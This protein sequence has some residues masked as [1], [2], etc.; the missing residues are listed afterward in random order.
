MGHFR[1]SL[2]LT[3]LLLGAACSTVQEPDAATPTPTA[4]ITTP[5][6][7]PTEA[8]TPTTTAVIPTPT[9]QPTEAA[10]TPTMQ[11]A[12]QTAPAGLIYKLSS[13]GIFQIQP[14]GQHRQLFDSQ[15]AAISNLQVS[16][17]GRYAAYVNDDQQ[18]WLLSSE[19]GMQT[20]LADSYNV[21]HFLLW[22]DNSTLL[23]GIWLDSSESE[24]PNN[25]HLARFNL[26]ADRAVHILDE[27]RL[28][29]G[30]PALSSA[31]TIAFDLIPTSANDNETSF[32]FRHDEGVTSFDPTA[33]DGSDGLLDGTRFNPAW[34]P[35]GRQLAWLTAAGERFAVQLFDLDA[36][37]AV[38]LHDWDPARFG[39]LV[40]S[41]VW[42]PD[43]KWLA[44]NVWANGTEGSGVWLL[45]ADGSSQ[46][47]VDGEGFDPRWVDAN[48]LFFSVD[49]SPRLYDVG[50][51]VVTKLDL[52]TG[53]WVL[54]FTSPN[55]L[56]ALSDFIRVDETPVAYVL[57]VQDVV[58]YNGP[59]ASY[60][61]IGTLFGGQTARVTGQ[62]FIT[63]WWRVICPDDTVGNCW[64]TAD[65][66]STIPTDDSNP[67]VALLN[68]DEL[69]I[70][71]REL[72][73][74][75]GRFQAIARRSEPISLNDNEQFY[76]EIV[77][78]NGAQTWS[79]AAGWRPYG[80]GFTYPDALSWSADSRYLYYTNHQTVGDGCDLFPSGGDL[81]RFDVEAGGGVELLPSGLA[82]SFALSPDETTIAYTVQKGSEI[83]LTLRDVA[84]YAEQSVAVATGSGQ[85]GSIVW[86]ADGTQ[87]LL[88]VAFEPCQPTQANSIVAVD[89]AAVTAVTLIDKDP[90]QFTIVEFTEPNRATLKD[91]DGQSWL[92]DLDNG[93]LTES[94]T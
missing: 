34:S 75:N 76:S 4:V 15:T 52:P 53:G 81:Y 31:G 1:F 90:R 87:L 68:P 47:L 50:S 70:E 10:A 60:N 71:T 82:A 27:T 85:S 24:G 23:F 28:S 26:D 58:M 17:N 92:L 48:T 12:T 78:S 13:D 46:M 7:Q 93:D 3:L 18:L 91:K 56:L 86:T 2:L 65:L 80:L 29:S 25:G 57:A 41:P 33:F 11:P 16:P 38:Q 88:T 66:A 89:V 49:G 94:G 20:Q 74:P 73:S 42:S 64:V 21:T 5:S 45:A 14:D 59:N 39:G 51:G 67:Q 77:V 69:Q 8:T 37:T 30:R 6:V 55:D 19:T 83:M 22:G 61:Q 9:M 84:S 62:S 79:L 36:Q 44:L 43:G 32:L 40:P 63:G 72:A 35:N 54:G